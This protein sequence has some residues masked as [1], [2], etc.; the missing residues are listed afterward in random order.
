MA[1]SPQVFGV[2]ETVDELGKLE[3]KF[4]F[5]A[6]QKMKKAAAPMAQAM[7][8]NFPEEAPISGMAYGKFAW[9][10]RPKLVVRYKAPS[11]YGTKSRYS[12]IWN[13]ISILTPK[14]HHG[15]E[16]FDMAQNGKLGAALTE[17]YGNA[18]RAMWRVEDELKNRTQDAI[19]DALEA[20]IR[21]VQPGLSRVRRY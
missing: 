19:L 10:G 16:M 9:R 21:E 11:K 1:L 8:A 13:L 3:A 15:A 4:K 18:S 17:R 14:G 5:Q 7:E 12:N 20:Y 2:R 6:I